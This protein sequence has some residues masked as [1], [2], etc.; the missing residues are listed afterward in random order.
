YEYA[1]LT[2]SGDYTHTFTNAAGCDSVVTLH[3]T[4][5]NPVHTAVTMSA[6]ESFIWNG[7][8]YT[9]SG[10]YTFAHEDA[11]GCT[12][13]DTLHL[14]INHGT[15]HIF[16]ENACE[17]YEWHEV[18]YTASGTYTYAYTTADD[19]ECVDTLHLTINH[20]VS[21]EFTIET[22]DSCYEWNGVSYCGTGDYTQTLT[23]ENG[24][25]SVVTM[26]L[27]TSV[28]INDNEVSLVYLAPNPTS[29]ICRIIGLSQEPQRVEL[30]DMHGAFIK[31]YQETELDVTTLVTGVYIVKVFTDNNV[32]NLK[33]V[34]Q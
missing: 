13:V 4:V 27:T 20:A 12:Q 33:L 10:D 23:S 22:S 8:E 15:H 25:D 17:S 9:T 29:N 7:T 34:K 31:R 18:T 26:H 19:C 24:C 6:C 30:Y 2:M 32:I 1:N 14:T 3:L 16:F 21:A 5:N 28:G 11:H